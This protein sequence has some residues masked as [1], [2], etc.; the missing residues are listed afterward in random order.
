MSRSISHTGQNRPTGRSP[1]SS[2]AAPTTNSN[3]DSRSMR[4]TLNCSAYRG[5]SS[6]WTATETSRAIPPTRLSICRS[7]M[8]N[9]P[10]R[11]R[12]MPIAATAARNGITR[13]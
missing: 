2:T 4:R 12:A 1:N 11:R 8:G 6:H 7:W 9:S 5:S 13:M 10:T 3:H